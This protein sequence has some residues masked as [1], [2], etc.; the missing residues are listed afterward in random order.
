MKIVPKIENE[1]RK[2]LNWD[3]E[4]F[5]LFEASLSDGKINDVR[6]CR[7]GSNITGVDSLWACEGSEEFLK[8]VHKALGQLLKYIK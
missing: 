7:Q 5:G 1:N 6:M 4:D 3:L 2:T 8:Q